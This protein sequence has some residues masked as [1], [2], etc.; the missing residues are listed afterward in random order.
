MSVHPDS[1]CG[2]KITRSPDWQVLLTLS[3]PVHIETIAVKWL[4][5]MV[6]TGVIPKY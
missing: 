1:W 3:K 2:T 5:E 4:P 6:E